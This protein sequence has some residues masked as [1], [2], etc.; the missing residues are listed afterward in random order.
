P[1]APA[2]TAPMPAEVFAV[3]TV[4]S[5]DDD[6][7]RLAAYLDQI[8]PGLGAELR[9]ELQ[10]PLARGVIDGSRPFHAVVLVPPPGEDEPD[11]LVV[12]ATRDPAGL[13]KELAEEAEDEESVA[14]FAGEWAVMG[15]PAVIDRAFAWAS[16]TLAA[17]PAP[18]RATAVL[19]AAPARARWEAELRASLDAPDSDVPAALREA[20]LALVE[21]TEKVEAFAELVDGDLVV[22]VVLTP[23]ADTTLARVLAAQRPSTFALLE[24]LPLEQPLGAMAGHLALGD[25]SRQVEDLAVAFIGSALAASSPELGQRLSALV[26]TLFDVG[27]GEYAGVTDI[28]AQAVLNAFG[29]RDAARVGVALDRVVDATRK[30]PMPP[31]IQLDV[32]RS[33]HAGVSVGVGTL[34]AGKVAAASGSWAAWDGTVAFAL[35]DPDGELLRAT[36]DG[37]RTP[38]AV[39]ADLARALADA[40]RRGDS[41]LSLF[42]VLPGDEYPI[43]LA[44]GVRSGSAYLWARVPAAQAAAL[45]AFRINDD[46]DDE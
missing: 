25:H 13:A 12:A 35:T 27:T 21:Q 3:L 34:F 38:R 2:P 31:G 14:R 16:T 17:A 10:E 28:A 32:Q 40:R 46:D 26:E 11:V 24:R 22:E 15:K 43:A 8:S 5:I 39:P 29:V 19:Y 1:A 45:A 44:L 4:P 6:V 37:T 30:L 20:L 23:R 36:V 9:A 7:P 41:L 33:T 42:D 18:T